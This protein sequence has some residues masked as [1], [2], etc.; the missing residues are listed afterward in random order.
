MRKAVI[1]TGPSLTH[2]EALEIFRD[3]LYLPPIRRGD[4]KKAI[5]EG[6]DIIGIIDGVFHQN[7][8][9]SP[10]EIL[11]VMRAGVT[12]IGGGSMGA[13]RAAELHEFGMIGVG[14]IFEMYRRGEI[15]S[16]DEVA[17]IFNPITLEPLSEPLINIRV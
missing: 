12:V 2:Q 13:L 17:L 6:F 7:V 11:D 5:G 4:A 8:A 14:R 15:D 9:I 1:F 3:A 16:D 10:R